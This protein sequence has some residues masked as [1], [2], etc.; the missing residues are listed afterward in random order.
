MNALKRFLSNVILSVILIFGSVPAICA[1]TNAPVSSDVGMADVGDFGIW[2]TENN[3]KLFLNSLTYDL[4]SFYGDYGVQLVDDYV[5]IEAKV[6]ISFMN[7]F[8]YV[9]H[10]LDS[11]LVR[12]T[13]IFLIIAYGFWLFFEAY[14]L[15]TG[16]NK[17]EDKTKEI[18]KNTIKVGAWVAVLSIGPAEI[19]MLIMSP[20]LYI[21]TIFSDVILNSVAHVAGVDLPDTCGAIHKY[22]AANISPDN[23][24]DPASAANIMCVPT[25]I[26]GFCY[27]AVKM[28][29][30]WLN[31][32]I[33]KSG[34]AFLCGGAF[35]IGFICLA[36]KFAFIAFGVIAD[37]FLG[38]IMLPFTA[39]AE[40]TAKT[41]YKGIAGNIFNGFL[42]LFTAE[43]LS[44]QISRVTGAA[45]HFIA[46]SVIISVCAALLSSVISTDNPAMVPQLED[47][48][49]WVTMFIAALTWWLA[50][51]A[52][53]FATEMGGKISYEMGTNL[54]NDA[55][56]LW[57]STKK[58]T[59]TLIEII[60]KS[61]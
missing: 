10:I 40:T 44:N 50:K 43:S 34:F 36:W 35:V 14:T 27:T 57:S 11:S 30:G 54:Q 31:W 12:F 21:G 28:G 45:L 18:I 17:V 23:I 8:S 20:I 37:L 39:I 2:T 33:G 13:I 38:I 6:G 47:Q 60:K 1:T 32:G 59:K 15:I 25:R 16:Q 46:L 41:T 4:D 53:N 52:T 51:K 56:N 49:F 9:A 42:K 48:G 55:K 61:K 29:W 3:R 24:I 7:A 22:A 26:S 19:F 5:P 58:G